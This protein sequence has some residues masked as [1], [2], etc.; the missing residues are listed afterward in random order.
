MRVRAARNALL[1]HRMRLLP[2]DGFDADDALVAG[3]VR[4][5]RRAG[6][7]ADRVEAGD[8]GFAIAVGDDVAAI[9]FHVE[10][11]EA[12]VLDVAG[13]ADSDDRM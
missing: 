11:F 12:E 7:I 1:D 9:G 6:D 8:I 2:G 4:Q 10:G 5:P 13:D 3:L